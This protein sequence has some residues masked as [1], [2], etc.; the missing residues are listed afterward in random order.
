VLELPHLDAQHNQEYS[1]EQGLKDDEDHQPY[2]RHLRPDDRHNAQS[3]ARERQQ[4]KPDHG[5]NIVGTAE[6]Q[7]QARNAAAN[8]GK[9]EQYQ[10]QHPCAG[11]PEA[12]CEA[13]HQRQRALDHHPPPALACQVNH[14]SSSF[15]R[16]RWH[17]AACDGNSSQG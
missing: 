5:K 7:H 15:D 4:G 11:R 9:R 17:I 10:Q 2:N 13:N 6:H 1:G 14:C 16:V 12:N 3:Q 8:R